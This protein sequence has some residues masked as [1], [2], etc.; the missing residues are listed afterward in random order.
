MPV[1]VSTLNLPIGPP[2]HAVYV[3]GDESL[4]FS[5]LNA[6]AGV[7][8]RIAGRFMHRDG[9]VEPFVERLVP[10]TDRT[11]SVKTIPLAEGW[12]LNAQ[13]SVSA[14]TPQIGQTFAILSL[15]R[16]R[17]GAFE[18]LATLA[19]GP[20]SAVQRIAWP[21]SVVGSPLE[22]AG[23]LRTITGATPAAGAEVSETVPT[24]ARWQLVSFRA[25]FAASAV[26]SNRN[27]FLQLDDGTTVL[28]QVI[29][30]NAVTASGGANAYW[31]AGF[32]PVTV[33]FGN[34]Q[35][36]GIGTSAWLAAGHRIRTLTIGIDAADTWTNV[37]YKVREF[38]EGA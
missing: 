26:V 9:R 15:V 31:M 23:A 38:L 29:Q 30:F 21:G 19:A 28:E 20:I 1:D 17:T 16:G 11:V 3:A 7:T 37:R 27:L 35:M 6:A 34:G 12:L 36:Q 18:E 25:T 33:N 13:A 4:R 14:G 8:V 2:A 32:G 10:A 22:G 5:V 24:G